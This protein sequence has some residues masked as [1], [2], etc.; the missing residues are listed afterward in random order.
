[1]VNGEIRRNK[2]KKVAGAEGAG[3]VDGINFLIILING[4]RAIDM[5]QDGNEVTS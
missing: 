2:V 5:P 1:M 3:V 4:L